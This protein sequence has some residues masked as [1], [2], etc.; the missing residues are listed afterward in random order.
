[1]LKYVTA[2]FAFG[3]A[4]GL[5]SL[6]LSAL[7]QSIEVLVF[8]IGAVVGV[9]IYGLIGIGVDSLRGKF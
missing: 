4:L 8:G 1:M 3:C 6:V 5:I 9:C 2:I 7:F